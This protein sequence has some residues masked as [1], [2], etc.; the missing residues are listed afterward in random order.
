MMHT[1][2]ADEGNPVRFIARNG[3]EHRDKHLAADTIPIYLIMTQRSHRADARDKGATNPLISLALHRIRR[4]L[5]PVRLLQ[6]P[7]DLVT[8]MLRLR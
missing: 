8:I 4:H 6:E 3:C 1:F 7:D 2:G 5:K